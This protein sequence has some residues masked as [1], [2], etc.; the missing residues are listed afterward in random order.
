ML[1][2][3]QT[4]VRVN[5]RFRYLLS[6]ASGGY[7]SSKRFDCSTRELAQQIDEEFRIFSKGLGPSTLIVGGVETADRHP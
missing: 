3:L 6:N 2:D 1:S 5:S 7:T 4:P